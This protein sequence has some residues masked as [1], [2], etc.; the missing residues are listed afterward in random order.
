MVIFEGDPSGSPSKNSMTVIS[1]QNYN[2]WARDPLGI[3]QFS[4]FN[5]ANLWGHACD[6]THWNAQKSRG[7]L[8]ISYLLCFQSV[9][10]HRLDFQSWGA[11]C[12]NKF[13][14][15]IWIKRII[16][17]AICYY[18]GTSIRTPL[19]LGHLPYQDTTHSPSYIKKCTKLPLKWG[20][21][22]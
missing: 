9:H 8:I 15:V 19:K 20:L 1:N 7:I 21:L 6:D 5:T 22:L 10:G 18:S 11:W 13:Y 14:G 2:A 16:E 12:T 3:P 17:S 4:S